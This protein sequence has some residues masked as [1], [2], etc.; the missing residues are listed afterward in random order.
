MRRARRCPEPSR[1]SI[2]STLLTGSRH[3]GRTRPFGPCPAESTAA[4]ILENVDRP[5]VVPVLVRRRR[6]EEQTAA[7][8]AGTGLLSDPVVRRVRRRYL[9]RS[10][11]V[12]NAAG[13]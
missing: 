11:S 3:V 2:Y 6:R 1:P 10:K 13:A 7:R 4:C 9:S 12:R 5:R 8:T